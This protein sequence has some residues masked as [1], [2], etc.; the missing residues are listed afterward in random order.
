MATPYRTLGVGF[1]LLAAAI[2]AAQIPPIPAGGAAP[3]PQSGA[4]ASPAAAA[5]HTTTRGQPP[6]AA[7][8]SAQPSDQPNPAAPAAQPTARPAPL[9]ASPTVFGGLSLNNVSLVEVIDLLARQLKITYILDPRVRRQRDPQYLRR[10]EGRRYALAA[11]HHSAAERRRHGAAGQHL[12]HRAAGRRFTPAYSS[13]NQD[14]L[15]R[16]HQR[17]SDHVQSD[18][19][20]VR[21]RRGTCR[22]Y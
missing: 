3:A 6:A 13:R 8:P 11:G 4:R 14:R 5:G 22:M 10:S 18:L 9:P 12:S 17:R 19:S 16:H 7:Q 21:H 20:Q 1:L 15:A 2:A